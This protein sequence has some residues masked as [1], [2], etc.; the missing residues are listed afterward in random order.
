M[1]LTPPISLTLPDSEQKEIDFVDTSFFTGDADQQLPTPAQVRA[2]S[3]D[4]ATR[5]QPTPVKYDELSLLVKFGPHVKTV[6]ALNLWTIKKRVDEDGY[7]FIYMELIRGPTLEECW[8]SLNITEKEAVSDQLSQIMGKLHNLAQ[9]PSERFIGSI[10]HENLHDYVFIDQPKTGP[11]SSVSEFNDWFALLHQLLL[12]HRYD[13]PNRSLLPDTGEI[14]LTHADLHRRNI[15]VASTSPVRVVIMDW[16]QS[17]WY[18]EYWEYC[19]ARK[20]HIDKILQPQEE[21]SFVFSEYTRA[22]GAI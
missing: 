3:K 14:K 9:D 13:D 4:S 17:G 5:P 12:G 16:Q 20:D 1:A 8:D 6:E 21:V 18:P 7:T 10:N 19:K 2:L 15:I 11:F 22:M